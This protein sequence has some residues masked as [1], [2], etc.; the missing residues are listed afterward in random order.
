MVR[1]AIWHRV[2]PESEAQASKQSKSIG[3]G[4]MGRNICRRELHGLN[5]AEAFAGRFLVH[6]DEHRFPPLEI[7]AVPITSNPDT[8]NL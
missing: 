7:S 8:S 2:Q 3:F 5:L 4:V 1:L 6:Y